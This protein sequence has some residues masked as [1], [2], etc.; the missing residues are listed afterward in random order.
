MPKVFEGRWVAGLER[1][2]LK[3]SSRARKA[4]YPAWSVGVRIDQSFA[5]ATVEYFSLQTVVD[6]A[7]QTPQTGFQVWA[8]NIGAS[9]VELVNLD[10]FQ[11]AVGDD[12]PDDIENTIVTAASLLVPTA[13]FER[14]HQSHEV[15]TAIAV[16]E[17]GLTQ[18]IARRFRVPVDQEAALLAEAQQVAVFQ[19]RNSADPF[20]DWTDPSSADSVISLRLFYLSLLRN[21]A[22]GR[23][24]DDT[25]DHF[26]PAVV[27]Q[28]VFGQVSITTVSTKDKTVVIDTADLLARVT[29]ETGKYDGVMSRGRLSWAVLLP[30]ALWN[31]LEN[32]PGTDQ[33][34]ADF[35]AIVATPGSAKAQ[36]LEEA[37]A[38]CVEADAIHFQ[39]W[40]LAALQ[41]GYEFYMC[42]SILGRRDPTWGPKDPVVRVP[43]TSTALILT[44]G[45]SVYQLAFVDETQE[46]GTIDGTTA[47]ALN[48]TVPSMFASIAAAIAAV[49]EFL[50]DVADAVWGFARSFAEW[51]DDAAGGFQE[52][53]ESAMRDACTLLNVL[54]P[55]SE[56][57]SIDPATGFVKYEKEKVDAFLTTVSQLQEEQ[58]QSDGKSRK[59]ASTLWPASFSP[60]MITAT[61]IVCLGI[62]FAGSMVAMGWVAMTAITKWFGAYLITEAAAYIAVE[63]DYVTGMLSSEQKQLIVF[64]PTV[65]ALVAYG[66]DFP[67]A[68]AVAS[69]V[70]YKALKTAAVLGATVV[71]SN[72]RAS[73]SGALGSLSNL[74]LAGAVVGVAIAMFRWNSLASD[75]TPR[76]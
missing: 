54:L 65:I 6:I 34:E 16:V 48:N 41:E 37:G 32:A 33:I 1:T 5:D 72:L 29:A 58:T 27:Q 38:G 71:V 52:Q 47:L 14:A 9:P 44:S 3:Q 60:P 11:R 12:S 36:W 20:V 56:N 43:E 76:S 13:G 62:I 21:L 24:P 22:L 25:R 59:A 75:A 68:F 61:I 10:R 39:A 51:V 19:P 8:Q 31:D 17:F 35:A 45:A 40:C 55:A 53:F 7:K 46:D 2:S 69:D 50:G 42:A 64:A 70:G 63:S 66:A 67:D 23:H 49:R 15:E 28:T 4:A 73:L 18:N 26:K 30:E 57:A 74:L